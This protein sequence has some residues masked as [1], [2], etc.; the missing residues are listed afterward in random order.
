MYGIE[1]SAIWK[2]ELKLLKINEGR[3]KRIQEN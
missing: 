2:K 3:Q 1:D